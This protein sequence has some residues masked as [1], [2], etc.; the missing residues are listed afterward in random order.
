MSVTHKRPTLLS[1]YCTLATA[2][3]EMALVW[4]K[5]GL[6]GVLFPE[7]SQKKLRERLHSRYPQ[8]NAAQK[9]PSFVRKAIRLLKLHLQSQTQDLSCLP[10]DLEH[11]PPFHQKIYQV[12]REIPSGKT[13]SYNEVARAAGSAKAARAV[14]QAMAKNPLPLIV[15]CHRVLAANGRLGGF[16]APGGLS[17]K[18]E[19]L[20]M[21]GA[22]LQSGP[23]SV[24]AAIKH[25]SRQDAQLGKIIRAV[26]PYSLLAQQEGTT[27]SYLLRSIVYQQ[28]TGKAAQTIL[29][30]VLAFYDG[31]APKPEDLLAT[32][33]EKLRSAGL[34]QNKI[35]AIQDLAQKTLDGVV[36]KMSLLEKM[37][38]EKIISL[39]T[40][41]RG[42]GRWTV[43]MLLIFRLGRND[44]LPID[45]Y[46][47]RKSVAQ[48]YG[49]K[50]LPNPKEFQ[51][52]GEKWRPYRTV[53]SWYLWRQLDLA[54]RGD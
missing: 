48:L 28:L 39:L 15:P 42:V 14:G 17:T 25:L 11:L 19:L 33:V 13:L 3:G 1:E 2:R 4:S 53:A 32:P 20:K 22:D 50:D 37:T 52:L 51:K 9:V 41:V 34:S 18:K 54:K 43:E 38:D 35:R 5:Q 12:V 24:K 30:R 47:L 46:A 27:F 6:T 21:E 45:D 49:L 23:F 16:S 44:V 26:G 40:E 29:S 7:A 36:P 8:A 10:L 31:R